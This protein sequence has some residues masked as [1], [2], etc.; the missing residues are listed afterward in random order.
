MY[1][2]EKTVKKCACS[3]TELKKC[4]QCVHG[5]RTQTNT[6]QCAA[7]AVNIAYG[8]YVSTRPTAGFTNQN[9]RSYSESASGL[10]SK[11]P[12]SSINLCCFSQVVR[13]APC[14]AAG[15]GSPPACPVEKPHRRAVGMAMA[16]TAAERRCIS[17]RI[18]CDVPKTARH[19][20]G[21]GTSGAR[22]EGH[23]GQRRGKRS[24]PVRP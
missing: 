4:T 13:P 11:S 19:G 9:F 12:F 8:L 7:G 22:H 6:V 20:G 1:T 23:G 17:A 15:P 3:R 24:R 2:N 16:L 18:L 10:R 14:R 21:I 5:R